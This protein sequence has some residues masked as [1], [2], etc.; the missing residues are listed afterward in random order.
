MR[1]LILGIIAL[2][3]VAPSTAG[4]IGP[5]PD[6]L[7]WMMSLLKNEAGYDRQALIAEYRKAKSEPTYTEQ[8]FISGDRRI[9]PRHPK[10]GKFRPPRRGYPLHRIGG[11]R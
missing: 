3:L 7:G 10:M 1:N 5:S 9:I 11:V 2:C 6:L 4:A 8:A